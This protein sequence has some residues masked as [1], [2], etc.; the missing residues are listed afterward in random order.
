MHA[1]EPNTDYYLSILILL[2]LCVCVYTVHVCDMVYVFRLHDNL[3]EF[4]PA[5]WVLEMKSRF[6][7]LGGS[8]L[9]DP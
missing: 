5:A 4:S 3:K 2:T 6:L 9:A 8:H 7:D 1:T